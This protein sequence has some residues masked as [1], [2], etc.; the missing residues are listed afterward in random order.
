MFRRIGLLAV[1]FAAGIALSAGPAKAQGL[2]PP[3]VK[4]G[5]VDESATMGGKP[6]PVIRP[7]VINAQTAVAC[8]VCFTCGG[9]WPVFSGETPTN[10][11][12]DERGGSCSGG[13]GTSLND[14]F[15]FLCCR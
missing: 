6:A 15:P 8:N 5:G 9:D 7:D 10:F 13:F 3:E 1:V 14:H 12:A 2:G 4:L 11:A